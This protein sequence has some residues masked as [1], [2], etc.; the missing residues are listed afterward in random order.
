MSPDLESRLRDVRQHVAP[1]GPAV[2]SRTEQ[3]LMDRFV[4]DGSHRPRLPVWLPMRRLLAG[5]LGVAAL[6]GGV[7]LLVAR[8]WL[9]DGTTVKISLGGD[10]PTKRT[11]TPADDQPAIPVE[12]DEVPQDLKANGASISPGTLRRRVF[13]NRPEGPYALWTWFDRRF[14][15][16]QTLITSPKSGW[17]GSSRCGPAPDPSSVAIIQCVGGRGRRNWAVGGRAL[18]EVVGIKLRTE[19]SDETGAVAHGYW[20]AAVDGA[21]VA[22]F[23]VHAYGRDRSELARIPGADPIARRPIDPAQPLGAADAGPTIPGVVGVDLDASVARLEA[24]GFV[25]QL[26]TLD[27]VDRVIYMERLDAGR[28]ARLARAG[29]VVRQFPEVGVAMAPGRTVT[30]SSL[31]HEPPPRVDA[32]A[33]DIDDPKVSVGI[34]QTMRGYPSGGSIT[35][36]TKLVRHIIADFPEGRAEAWT[37]RGLLGNLVQ[38]QDSTGREVGFLITLGPGSGA[39]GGGVLGGV[40]FSNLEKPGVFP[41][42]AGGSETGPAGLALMIGRASSRVARVTALYR[43]GEEELPLGGG[44]WVLIPQGRGT[45]LALIA[46]DSEGHELGRL[47][48]VRFQ[49]SVGSSPQ[50]PRELPELVRVPAGE[51]VA[52]P[53]VMGSSLGVPRTG[54][55]VSVEDA[56]RKLL[57]AGFKVEIRSTSRVGFDGAD[58]VVG[59]VPEGGSAMPA[60]STVLLDVTAPALA[61][62]PE[63]VSRLS[64]AEPIT[65]SASPV[66]GVRVGIVDFSNR[67][68][69]P[70]IVNS[71]I[72]FGELRGA[73][74]AGG[75]YLTDS[76]PP[77]ESFVLWAPGKE[78][79]GATFARRLGI[80]RG[81]STEGLPTE[82][83]KTPEDSTAV[84]GDLTYDLLIV[85]GTKPL[86][87]PPSPG[88]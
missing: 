3:A 79:A 69:P 36:P 1:P 16:E 29:E 82:F 60:G 37:V 53:D 70:W 39:G 43:N 84:K 72:R 4:R 71:K 81:G 54:P 61:A 67:S 57:D 38:P 73:T 34:R 83:L 23:Q 35:A 63:L 80:A 10:G 33:L 85:L 44:F 48:G 5:S 88:P 32:E 19:T 59:Q 18:P 7:S 9:D 49:L 27:D 51:G 22:G 40:E 46:R 78:G 45:P 77:E 28:G 75:R 24:L 42:E 21:P 2:T 11:V 66:A 47:A 74:M 64:K 8:P 55:S 76:D 17:E 68:T 25:V 65:A 50:P 14:G 62:P 31:G 6:A 15:L 87:K 26:R 20:I 41:L 12:S 58:T 56:K 52:V 30:L 86:K 13:V